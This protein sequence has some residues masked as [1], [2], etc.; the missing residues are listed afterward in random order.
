MLSQE[1]YTTT[2]STSSQVMLNA[3]QKE[4]ISAEPQITR[5]ERKAVLAKPETLKYNVPK[6]NHKVKTNEEY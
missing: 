1:N 6:Y 4:N 5:S 3:L 2:C